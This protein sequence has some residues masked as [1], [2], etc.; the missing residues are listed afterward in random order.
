[1][2]AN[3]VTPFRHWQRRFRLGL[4]EILRRLRY[5]VRRVLSRDASQVDYQEWVRRF[6]S[7]APGLTASGCAGWLR[8]E[9]PGEATQAWPGL[10]ALAW[11]PSVP[12]AMERLPATMT[13]AVFLAPGVAVHAH[14]PGWLKAAV[15]RP[16]IHLAFGDEDTVDASGVRRDPYFKPEWDPELLLEQDYVAGLF[17]V[18][19]PALERALSRPLP[20]SAMRNALVLRLSRML[21]RDAVAR[22]PRILSHRAPCAVERSQ[23]LAALEDWIRDDG[24]SPHAVVEAGAAGHRIQWR[25]PADAPKVSVVIPTRDQPRHLRRCLESVSSTQGECPVEIVLVDNGTRDA[26]ALQLLDMAAKKGA[27]VL[28]RDE[29]FNFSRLVNAGVQA[30]KGELVCLLNNDI[31]A[32]SPGWVDGLAALAMRPEVAAVG[33]LLTYPDGS[34]QHAGILCGLGGAAANLHSGEPAGTAGPQGRARCRQQFMAV[35]AACM[36]LRRS[37]FLDVGGFDIGYPVAFNDVDFCL[38]LRQTGRR[39]VWTPDVVLRHHESASRG[40]DDTD[41]RR[42]RMRTEFERLRSRWADQLDDD[43]AYNPNLTLHGK[44]FQLTL[45]PRWAQ[46]HDAPAARQETWT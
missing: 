36:M 22:V 20:A 42:S 40:A 39:I 19:R 25:L 8:L 6:E 5:R 13:H 15:A 28:R 24:A 21:A 12:G 11:D 32:I 45:V 23:P 46:A 14:A 29:P 33:A 9:L 4:P 16:G 1:M 43:P 3:P 31:Q 27:Q 44:A 2:Q 18:S 7:A 26:E 41:A 34:I 30:S 38:R 37:L 17:V 35:T 10:P